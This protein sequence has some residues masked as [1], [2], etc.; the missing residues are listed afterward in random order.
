ML[1]IDVE[2]IPSFAKMDA[3]EF[4]TELILLRKTFL[5]Y[6]GEIFKLTAVVQQ[7]QKSRVCGPGWSQARVC[8]TQL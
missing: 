8:G 1:A 2:P 6:T 5:F 3:D 7:A 4:E